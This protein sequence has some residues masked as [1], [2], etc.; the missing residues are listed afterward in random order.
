MRTS[1]IVK[2]LESGEDRQVIETFLTSESIS[3]GDFVA[4]DV[5]KTPDGDKA[6]YIRKA[7]TATDRTCVVGV[8][9]TAAASGAKLEV[10]VRGICE[11]SVLAAAEG[12]ALGVTGTQGAADTTTATAVA[13]LLETAGAPGLFTVY[14]R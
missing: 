7:S 5:T 8:A 14:V 6:L 10:I 3:R 13:Y 4:L 11:A 2:R 1:P 9:K 12:D